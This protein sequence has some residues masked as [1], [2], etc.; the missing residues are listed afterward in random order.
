MPRRRRGDPYAVTRLR[1]RATVW[2]FL[3]ARRV[4]RLL[5]AGPAYRLFD[6]AADRTYAGNGSSVQR[7]R[8]NY[9]RVRPELTP[10][11]LED[12][13]AKGVR[14]ALRYYVEAFRLPAIAGDHVDSVVRFRGG[15]AA[16][17]G[18]PAG[19]A[20]G[21]GLLG[22]HRQL[23]PRG[24]LVRPP[25]GHRRHRRRAARAGGDVPGLPRL[26]RGPGHGDPPGRARD[27]RQAAR[28]ARDG[29]ARG[30]AA[31]RSTGTSPPAAS[32][33]TCAVT[34]PGWRRGRRPR[35]SRAVCRSTRSPCATSGSVAPGAWSSPSTTP[36]T[37]PPRAA[38][39]RW[40][41]RRRPAPMPSARRS[42]RT[43]RTGT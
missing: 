24:R 7:L 36:S 29:R 13:T 16:D 11:E 25:P 23:G 35:P 12:L 43:R 27:L 3:L 8:A 34:A 22:A 28:A 5:P 9:A 40:P 14:A 18:A 31:A 10:D 41:A 39:T 4:L 2:A 26:P 42:S 32:R 30:H 6:L 20:T 21:P 17:E 37:S 15:H 33:W 1:R 19:R 38:R